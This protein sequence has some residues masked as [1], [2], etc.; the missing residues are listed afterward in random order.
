MPAPACQ[1]ARRAPEARHRTLPAR[2]RDRAQ[3][4]PACRCSPEQAPLTGRRATRRAG[5]SPCRC[6]PRHRHGAP[7]TPQSHLHEKPSTGGPAQPARRTPPRPQQSPQPPDTAMPSARHRLAGHQPAGAGA[8]RAGPADAGQQPGRDHRP[9]LR[10]RRRQQRRGIAGRD[11]RRAAEEPARTAPWR[12]AGIRARR[13][14]HPAL[15]RRQGQPVLP[16]R[17][18]P[19]PRHRLRHQRQR[20]AGQHAQPR[21]WPGLQRLELPAARAGGPHR[22]PQGPVLCAERRLRF[23]RLGRHRLPHAAGRAVRRCHAGA[24]RLPARR[25]GW[26]HPPGQR[27]DP[28]GRAGAAAQRRPLDGARRPAQDQCRAHPERRHGGRR[29]ACQP[30]ALPGQVD[31]DRPDPAA[32]DRCRQPQ[33]PAL[34]PL[35]FPRPHGRRRHPAHQ[36][37]GTVAAPGRGGQQQAVG[38]PDRLPAGPVLQLHLCA[39]AAGHR[40][41]VRPA[42]QPPRGR[43]GRQPD[44]R[45]QPGRAGR[46]QRDRPATA[47]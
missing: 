11:P 26:L 19:R 42:R 12:G 17:L 45:P 47:P 8:A 14:R 6:A 16:A 4:R 2:P 15:G 22:L 35:R 9:A 13:H 29:L 30:D 7:P 41:P 28:A 36:P 1:S 5:A 37:V 31:I 33:R 46:A 43:P 20:P 34:R 24:E 38:L 27:P 39:G 3:R 44:H 23:C 10:Q 21:P 25:G 18:Q 32:A 40:R